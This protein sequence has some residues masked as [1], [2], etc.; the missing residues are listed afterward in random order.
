M[1]TDRV[2]ELDWWQLTCKK[3][4]YGAGHLLLKNEYFPFTQ[5]FWN[6]RE[7]LLNKLFLIISDVIIIFWSNSTNA[8][9]S[10]LL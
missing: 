8:P 2:C 4:Q 9:L 7:Q 6:L 1:E 5:N 3:C 10:L